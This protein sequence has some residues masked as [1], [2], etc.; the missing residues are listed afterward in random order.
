[1]LGD[2]FLADLSTERFVHS[3]ILHW[4]T[5]KVVGLLLNQLNSLSLTLQGA[6]FPA[7]LSI[8]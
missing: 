5:W 4:L 7:D 6:L 1:M 3:W 8:E 2:L